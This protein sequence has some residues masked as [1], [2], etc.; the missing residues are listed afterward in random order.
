MTKR[1]ELRMPLS[2][3]DGKTAGTAI[4][5]SSGEI[6]AAVTTQR[7]GTHRAG[8]RWLAEVRDGSRTDQLAKTPKIRT[9]ATYFARVEIEFRRAAIGLEAC[10]KLRCAGLVARYNEYNK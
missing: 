8:R 7:A 10:H 4:R 2:G 3:F 9:A 5:G 6:R 1:Q